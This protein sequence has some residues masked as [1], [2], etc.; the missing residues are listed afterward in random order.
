MT[1]KM[2]SLKFICQKPDLRIKLI[3]LKLSMKILRNSKQLIFQ[4][5]FDFNIK[6][7]IKINV[8]SVNIK[9]SINK[10]FNISFNMKLISV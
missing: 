3:L 2:F 1:L 6:L 5:K 7:D 10:N 4:Y 9:I 8:N